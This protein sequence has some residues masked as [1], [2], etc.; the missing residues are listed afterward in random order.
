MVFQREE[1]RA[2]R[3][4][5]EVVGGNVPVFPRHRLD[6]V[7]DRIALLSRVDD[8]TRWSGTPGERL[9]GGLDDHGDDGDGGGGGNVISSDGRDLLSSTH[10]DYILVF[11]PMW[12]SPKRL[13]VR[14]HSPQ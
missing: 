11:L 2:R 4:A 8:D 13:F 1:Q 14:F 10:E 7:E 3:D 6:F 12:S 9:R 5:E